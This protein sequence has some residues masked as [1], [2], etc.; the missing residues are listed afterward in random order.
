MSHL[1]LPGSFNI[2]ELINKINLPKIEFVQSSIIVIISILANL[3]VCLCFSYFSLLGKVQ[4]KSHLQ[5]KNQ[6]RGNL[7]SAAVSL[8]ANFHAETWSS[9]SNV[10]TYMYCNC[11]RLVWPI[12]S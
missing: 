4:L 2:G 11:W 10:E 3:D 1:D 12:I 8:H 5:N 9:P 7:V 6:K